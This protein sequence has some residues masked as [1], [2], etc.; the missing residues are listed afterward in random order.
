[1][2]QSLCFLVSQG[3]SLPILRDRACLGSFYLADHLIEAVPG[4][5]RTHASCIGRQIL[6]HQVTGEAPH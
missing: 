1:M 6:H 2:A 4:P 3:L 5:E